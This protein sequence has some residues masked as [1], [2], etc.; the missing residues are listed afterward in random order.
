M[1]GVDTQIGDFTKP[2]GTASLA[3]VEFSDF[4]CP[5]CGWY[6]RD[7]YAELNREF[8]TTG[9]VAYGFR[10]FPLEHAHPMALLAAETAACAGFQGRFWEMHDMLFS[11]QRALA[12]AN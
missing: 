9:K 11:N 5:F 2:L 4:Q 12:P 1:S 8:I 10:N 3:I 6:A 7:T